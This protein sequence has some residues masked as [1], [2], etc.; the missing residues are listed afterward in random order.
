VAHQP[1]RSIAALANRKDSRRGAVPVMGESERRAF[2][3][4]QGQR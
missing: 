3:A 2:R 4:L 1:A